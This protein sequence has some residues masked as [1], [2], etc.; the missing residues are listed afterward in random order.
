MTLINAYVAPAAKQKFVKQQIDL[1]PLAPEDVEI[2]VEHFATALRRASLLTTREMRS[3]SLELGPNRL[4]L[5]SRSPDVGEAKV[6]L[7]VTYAEAAEKLGFNPDYL[8]DALKVME[9]QRVVRFE[10]TSARA[11]AKLSD[12]A[13]YV[14]VVSP[15][16][17]TE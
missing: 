8:L 2:K 7:E 11:P 9:P 4:T 12:G 5:S 1:G 6:E 14:Y 13:E 15:V 3:V 16:S 10:V 17:V